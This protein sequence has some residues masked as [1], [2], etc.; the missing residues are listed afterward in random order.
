MEKDVKWSP[1][2]EMKEVGFD[3]HSPSVASTPRHGRY[4]Y[5]HNADHEISQKA[6]TK[7]NLKFR[8]DICVSDVIVM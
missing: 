3:L 5:I 6:L 8:N 1:I 7:R 2:L 4:L